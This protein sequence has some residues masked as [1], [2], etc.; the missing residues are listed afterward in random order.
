MLS[1][2]IY[3][4]FVQCGEHVEDVQHFCKPLNGAFFF[5]RN[6]PAS[7][8]FTERQ[9]SGIFSPLLA[10]IF[11]SLS[12]FTFTTN[13]PGTRT[14]WA[15]DFCCIL[16]AHR[17]QSTASLATAHNA[18]HEWASNLSQMRCQFSFLF[19]AR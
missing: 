16:T 18:Q 6:K 13:G 5:N 17:N 10:D 8:H 11:A 3:S 15:W 12:P 7:S 2:G 14:R 19:T 9:Q 1:N 4:H